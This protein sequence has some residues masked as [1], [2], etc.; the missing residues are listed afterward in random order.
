[1]DAPSIELPAGYR[2]QR[3]GAVTSTSDL[4]RA[5]AESGEAD[6]LIVTADTQTAGRGRRGRVW[7]SQQGGLYFSILKR[8]PALP[9]DAMPAQASLVT[10]IALIEALQPLVITTLTLKWP[11]DVLASGAK[12]AG[13]LV[14]AE[15]EEA[16]I[17]GIGINH[18]SAPAI[19][20]QE[21]SCLVD[22]GA[23]VSGDAV[24]NHVIA[25]FDRRW[26]LWL[27]EG[28]APIRS[29]WASHGPAFGTP[30]SVRQDGAAERGSFAG[31]DH[32]GSLLLQP[33]DRPV[34]RIA[35]GEIGHV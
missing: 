34:K 26:R 29:A 19:P 27:N 12:L 5:A 32:D 3:H 22:L 14:E 35:A 18:R 31:L 17:I 16:L 28:F 7:Q 1:M 23:S 13:V 21:T 33:P 30:I 2:L 20:E 11:N 10:G 6:G 25:A 4:I 8:L 15:R 24:L 9:P